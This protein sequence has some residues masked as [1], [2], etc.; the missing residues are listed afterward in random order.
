MPRKIILRWTR[1]IWNWTN[2]IENRNGRGREKLAGTP[3][4]S[5]LHTLEPMVSTYVTPFNL[6]LIVLVHVCVSFYVGLV[7][8]TDHILT[9]SRF[10]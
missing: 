6:Q 10:N 3:N 8:R 2:A 9:D 7:N 5:K 4:H 1:L